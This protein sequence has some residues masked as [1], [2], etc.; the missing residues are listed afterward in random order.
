VSPD[1]WYV[2]APFFTFTVGILYALL[3]GNLVTKSVMDARI[4]DKEDKIEDTQQLAAFWE[5][6]AR[7]KDRVIEEQLIPA[8]ETMTEDNRVTVKLIESL[9]PAGDSK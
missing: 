7:K 3:R 4:K 8:I 5:M 6:A 2:L 1:V 9:R